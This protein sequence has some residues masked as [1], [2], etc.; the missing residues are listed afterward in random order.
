MEIVAHQKKLVIKKWQFYQS[1]IEFL[2][3][4]L[5]NLGA[6]GRAWTGAR[7][8][9]GTGTERGDKRRIEEV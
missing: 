9:A 5:L 1:F 2:F 3:K 8:G 4:I 7:A 6:G